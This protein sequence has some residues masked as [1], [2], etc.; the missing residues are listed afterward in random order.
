MRIS[1]WSSDVCSSDLVPAGRAMTGTVVRPETSPM[2][3]DQPVQRADRT[4]AQR[5]GVGQRKEQTGN[6]EWVRVRRCGEE[7]SALEHGEGRRTAL[8]QAQG[9]RGWASFKWEGRASTCW[10]ARISRAS[11]GVSALAILTRGTAMPSIDRKRR[12]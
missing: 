10:R 9:E 6:S 2:R 1:D 3:V 8:R 5:G 12:G 7:G 11:G 4:I